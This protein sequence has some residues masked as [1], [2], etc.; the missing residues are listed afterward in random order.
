MCKRNSPHEN[1]ARTGCVRETAQ[2][3]IKPAWDKRNSS[4]K[5]MKRARDV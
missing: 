1:K 2:I 4:D 5:K 3:K